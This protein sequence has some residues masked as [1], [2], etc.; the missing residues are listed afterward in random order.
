M[1]RHHDQGNSYKG[2]I[3]IEGG[4]K[5]QRFSSL[6]SWMERM[7]AWRQTWGRRIQEFYILFWRKQQES[8]FFRK[9]GGATPG[10]AGAQETSKLSYTVTNSLQQGHTSSNK[11]TPPSSAT[12]YGQAFKHMSLWGGVGGKTIQ[13]TTGHDLWSASEKKKMGVMAVLRR[14]ADVRGSLPS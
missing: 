3:L 2:K 9:P 4:L 1:K 10:E 7:V 11:A 12:S 14:Q 13:T 6:S 8:V 5:F